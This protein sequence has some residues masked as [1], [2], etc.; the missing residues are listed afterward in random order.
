MGNHRVTVVLTPFH[1]KIPRPIALLAVLLVTLGLLPGCTPTADVK[2]DATE[3]MR[4][5]HVFRDELR[6][7]GEGPQ[8]VVIP[9][10]SFRMGDATSDFCEDEELP[11]HDVHIARPFAMGRYEVTFAEY[12]RYAEATGKEKPDDSWNTGRGNHPVIHVN[13]EDAQDYVEWLSQETGKNYRLPSEAEWEYA[14]RA[15]TT[16]EY[17]WG[18]RP[19][20]RHANGSGYGGWPSDGYEYTAPVGSFLPNRFG[21]YDMSGN[22]EEWV[23]DCWHDGY[24]GVPADGSARTL[25]D[26]GDCYRRV[27]R[28]GDFD[29]K[30]DRLRS[31]YRYRDWLWESTH[32]TSSYGFRLVRTF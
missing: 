11:V 15:G 14:A 7:G 2:V 18:D 23:E 17:Y 5:G 20:G 16:T 31:A 6:S 10:G 21:L 1:R 30:P 9:A 26:G 13:W 4:P 12:D 22:V 28:G 24:E 19:S 3:N 29:S 32:Y 25:A 8:M 27:L